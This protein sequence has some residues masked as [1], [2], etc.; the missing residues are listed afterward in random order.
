M[1]ALTLTTLTHYLFTTAWMLGTLVLG[2]L[3][4]LMD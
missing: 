3:V 1:L 4:R 2:T